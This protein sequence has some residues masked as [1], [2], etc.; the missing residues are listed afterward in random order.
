[1]SLAFKRKVFFM[2]FSEEYSFITL[3]RIY[4]ML[5]HPIFQLKYRMDP[6]VPRFYRFLVL[7]TRVNVTFGLAFFLLRNYSDPGRPQSSPMNLVSLAIFI[8]VG[9]LLYVPIPA[10]FYN[11]VKSEFYLLKPKEDD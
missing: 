5:L 8:V 7:F 1:M 6:H 9:S 3:F 11:C 10:T 4:M 2:D